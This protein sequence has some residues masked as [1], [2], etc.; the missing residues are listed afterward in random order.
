MQMNKAKLLGNLQKVDDI[1]AIIL[2][3]VVLISPS[4]LVRNNDALRR[5]L[6]GIEL[7]V[8]LSTVDEDTGIRTVGVTVGVASLHVDIQ[9]SIA[10]K[11][12]TCLTVGVTKR[13]AAW[14]ANNVGSI[15]GITLNSIQAVSLVRV[16][17]L[18]RQ[19]NTLTRTY[20]CST[21]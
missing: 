19:R 20:T 18:R 4:A 7:A 3:S 12:N 13:T 1:R 21:Q 14:L 6:R 8:V 10:A 9:L 15:E 2:H 11:V 5:L 17:A 16:E